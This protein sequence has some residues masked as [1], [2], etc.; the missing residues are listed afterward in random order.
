VLH[1]GRIGPQIRG[2]GPGI[3]SA[4]KPTA[5]GRLMKGK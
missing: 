5:F 4:S 2:G 3:A 1:G